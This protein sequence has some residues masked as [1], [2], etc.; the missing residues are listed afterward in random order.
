M[1]LH[2]LN[3]TRNSGEF[4]PTSFRGNAKKKQDE[5][6]RLYL[7][8]NLWRVY[9]SLLMGRC[10]NSWVRPVALVGA[11]RVQATP[12]QFKNYSL[13]AFWIIIFV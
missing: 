2:Q 4:E 5:N 8:T 6:E 12:L 7:K 10:R 11:Q 3:L 1:R 13:R 9:Q